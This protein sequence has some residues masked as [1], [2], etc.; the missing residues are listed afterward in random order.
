M[1]AAAGVAEIPLAPYATFGSEALAA[2]YIG[3]LGVGG[4]VTLSPAQMD[5]VLAAFA[6]YG[7]R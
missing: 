6:D 4:G 1:I 3:T 5:E 7:Q 2:I